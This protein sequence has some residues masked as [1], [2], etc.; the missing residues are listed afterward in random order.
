MGGSIGQEDAAS[1][2]A[3]IAEEYGSDVRAVGRFRGTSDDF[4]PVDN[5]RDYRV[6]FGIRIPDD[7][8]PAYVAIRRKALNRNVVE[9]RFSLDDLPL[10]EAY[11]A[12]CVAIV[13]KGDAVR[14]FGMRD[15]PEVESY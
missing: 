8:R 6:A 3:R 10:A 1:I 11:F 13:R 15:D 14:S 12:Q 7:G 2:L 9:D 4:V 5:G